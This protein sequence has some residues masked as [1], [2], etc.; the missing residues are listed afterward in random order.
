MANSS[1]NIL[2]LLVLIMLVHQPVFWKFGL[3][4]TCAPG[5]FI[6]ERDSDC[7]IITSQILTYVKIKRKPPQHL[8]LITGSQETPVSLLVTLFTSQTIVHNAM[9]CNCSC[10]QKYKTF[11]P[12]THAC[13][14]EEVLFGAEGKH[15]V[16]GKKERGNV[17]PGRRRHLLVTAQSGRQLIVKFDFV[18]AI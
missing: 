7:F 5:V 17:V 2:S 14:W 1:T 18:Q 6:F 15:V 16:G 4:I 13:I 12:K 9:Q 10:Y 11:L 8:A 3:S